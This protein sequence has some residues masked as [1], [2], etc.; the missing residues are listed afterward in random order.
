[1][2]RTFDILRAI[3]VSPE[4]VFIAAFALVVSL[5]PEFFISL[6]SR[7]NTTEDL[8]KY[9]ALIP[10][11]ITVILMTKRD[12]L[13]FPDQHPAD[14]LLQK[15]SG[16]HLLLDRYWICI[17]WGVLC[18]IPTLSIWI[19]SGDL[20]EYITF[21]LFFGGILTP[22]VTLLTFFV[23]TITLKRILSTDGIR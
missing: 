6:A 23:A 4:A 22:I 10:A 13:L 3:L 7:I 5:K 17:F 11:S 2:K 8:I 19:F 14:F 12:D 21:S 9:L 20:T 15:W 1:M 16:Y 18:S